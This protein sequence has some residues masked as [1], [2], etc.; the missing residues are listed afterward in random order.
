MGIL[1]GNPE[2][3]PM[4]YGEVFGIWTQV[5]TGKG[6]VA[7]YQTFMN[8]AG[9]KDLKKLLQE[10]IDICQREIRK[11]QPVQER[12][13]RKLQQNCLQMLQGVSFHIVQ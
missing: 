5:M 12:W 7:G 4:H 8:H 11:F 1:S 10:A 2:H 3:E 9:D 13:I 6:L